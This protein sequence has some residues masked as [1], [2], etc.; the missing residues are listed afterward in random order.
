MYQTVLSNHNSIKL[1]INNK[2]YKVVTLSMFKNMYSSR[3]L[4]D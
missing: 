3:Y 2:N 4:T 1:K